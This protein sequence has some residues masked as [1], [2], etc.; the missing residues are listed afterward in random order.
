MNEKEAGDG[1]LKS[2]SLTWLRLRDVRLG[3]CWRCEPRLWRPQHLTCCK[4][5][6]LVYPESR[7][8]ALEKILFATDRI[9]TTRGDFLQKKLRTSKVR[10]FTKKATDIQGRYVLLNTFFL[11]D[12]FLPISRLCFMS[13]YQTNIKPLLPILCLIY[14]K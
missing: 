6:K 5:S 11:T 3:E 7:G 14:L 12:K 1:P 9:R 10:F 4:A 13:N 2:S 8:F